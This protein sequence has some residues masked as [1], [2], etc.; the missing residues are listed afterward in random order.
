MSAPTLAD[1]RA[2]EEACDR[3]FRRYDADITAGLPAS[4][5]KA[6]Y[7]CAINTVQEIK[8]AREQAVL[9]EIIR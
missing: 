4:E 2:A 8:H 1:E 6:A 3:A 7:L 9:Q 5:S